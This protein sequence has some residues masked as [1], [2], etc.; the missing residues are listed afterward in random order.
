M[1]LDDP[2]AQRTRARL[3]A[4]ILDLAAERPLGSITMSA[5][6]GRAEVNRATVYLHYP[7]ID[8]LIA[9]AMED[10]VALVARAAAL[11]PLDAP[12]D[13]VPGPLAELFEHVEANSTLYSRMLD[14]QGS[15]RF[16]TRMRD[17]L[18]AELAARFAK[19]S[20]PGGY[21]D[22][23]PEIHA[24]YLAGALTGVIAHWVT[25]RHPGTAHAT[26]LAFWRLFRP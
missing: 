25:G 7:D 3:R 1:N 23:A 11:C 22:V 14:A 6:A 12:R 9:D 18:T 19:G 2:R 20:R 21:G 16:A 26:A 17:R 13:T 8:S 15:A 4:A 10:A 5:V 24:A